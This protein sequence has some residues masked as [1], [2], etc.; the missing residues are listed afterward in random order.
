LDAKL[1]DGENNYGKIRNFFSTK[2]KNAFYYHLSSGWCFCYPCWATFYYSSY[3]K[4]MPEF[5]E[6]FGEGAVNETPE[7]SGHNGENFGR[8]RAR[9]SLKRGRLPHVKKET[10]KVDN[11]I[12]PATVVDVA[13][14][15]I[16]SR[17]DQ[18]KFTRPQVVKK[19]TEVV[20]DHKKYPASAVGSNAR[21]DRGDKDVPRRVDR[22]TNERETAQR[23]TKERPVAESKSKGFCSVVAK[24]WK[25]FVAKLEQ[26]CGVRKRKNEPYVSGTKSRYSEKKMAVPSGCHHDKRIKSKKI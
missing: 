23:W 5:E 11:S 18:N 9:Y 14:D 24:F 1:W 16:G 12:A 4:V 21:D 13:H 6:G 3:V 22:R 19:S 26:F 25:N 17:V 7:V 2:V 20:D 8:T 10:A 15:A